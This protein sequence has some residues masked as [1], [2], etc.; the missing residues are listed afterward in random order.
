MPIYKIKLIDRKS[1]AKDTMAFYFEKPANF[2]FIPG[3]FGGFT[4]I[5]PEAKTAQ[6]TTRRFS[7]AGLPTSET[8]IIATRMRD[9]AYK[10]ALAQLP[11]GSELKFAGPAGKFILPE[12]MKTPLVMIAG[13]I[14]ITPF[15]SMILHLLANKVAQ[16]IY[17]FY[18]NQ[19]KNTATFLD[20]F[21]QLA[22]ENANFH[23]IPIFTQ[24]VPDWR[25]EKGY[26]NEKMLTGYISDD[27]SRLIYYICGS[28]G[29]ILSIHAMLNAIG[30]LD[31]AIHEEDFPGY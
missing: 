26:I 9:S 17:L 27:L 18:A 5:L 19:T 25:G 10:R 30:I 8:I 12:E 21:I 13:G 7:L 23:F 15:H 1:L 24:P 20:D 14:G 22:E 31:Q 29:F 3:Q 6:D 11:I 2:N 16:P 28:Q 4:L